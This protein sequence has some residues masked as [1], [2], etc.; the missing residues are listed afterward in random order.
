MIE[1]LGSNGN[2]VLW[3]SNSIQESAQATIDRNIRSFIDKHNPL[4]TSQQIIPRMPRTTL[5]LDEIAL[6]E[7]IIELQV[8]DLWVRRYDLGESDFS[9]A[10]FTRLVTLGNELMGVNA[11]QV[12]SLTT[13]ELSSSQQA[14]ADKAMKT[15]L[16]KYR[17]DVEYATI[18][19]MPYTNLTKGEYR[20]LIELIEA[21]AGDLWQRY[22]DSDLTLTATEREL[23]EQL[24]NEIIGPRLFQVYG[25]GLSISIADQPLA[26]QAI[27]DWL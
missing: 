18:R 1:F 7:R 17:E 3:Q 12:Y 15:F 23:V 11:Y 5:L 26:D 14:E 8:G 16:E 24:G 6:I 22:L 27:R 20:K 4:K 13:N 21:R 19:D 9:L 10:E 2:L 25:R